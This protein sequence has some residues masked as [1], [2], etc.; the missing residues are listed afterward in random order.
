LRAQ[1]LAGKEYRVSR[2]H[3]VSWTDEYEAR[4]DRELE[5]IASK[6]FDSYFFVV[7]DMIAWAKQRMLV[8]PGR[9]SSAGSLVCYLLGIT[10]VDPLPFKLL[11]ERFIDLTRADLPDIDVDFS[12]RKR[13]L[14]FDY[15]SEKYGRDCVARI[16]NINTMKPRTVMGKIGEVFAIPSSDVFGLL[17]VLIEYSSGDSRYGKSLEDTLTL[18]DPGRT[19]VK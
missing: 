5:A 8:G 17:N 2:G 9:G 7:A 1:A 10:E 4:M 6:G 13:E 3:I 11:F 12:D 18:T 15:L 16:G 19:F 14:V